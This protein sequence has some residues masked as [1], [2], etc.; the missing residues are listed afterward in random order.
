MASNSIAT[1]QLRR[2]LGSVVHTDRNARWEASFDSS[3]LSYLPD[4]VIKPRNAADIGVALVLANRH[5]VPVTVRGRG[6]TLTG[7]A[8]PLHGGWVVDLTGMHRVRIDAETGMAH[9]QAGATNAAVRAAAEA[10]GWFYPPDPSSDKYCTIGGNI[11]CNAGGMHGGKYGV[12]RDYVLALK[13]F[14]P[15]GEWVEWGTAT[16]KFSAGFNLRDLWIGSEGL[17]GIVT[18]AVLK[19]IPLPS[20][21]WTLLTSF[22]DEVTALRAAREC[23]QIPF[24]RIARRVQWLTSK[25]VL[26]S[27]SRMPPVLLLC[28][29][30]VFEPLSATF[31][32]RI[33]T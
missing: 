9:V 33:L 7:A 6:T 27:S 1:A 2:K 26:P 22:T 21:R 10:E 19:L 31:T 8:V 12:T 4:A 25:S 24:P 20:T 30:T 13:G 29:F 11:A 16:K 3:K 15:T 32:R 28:S 14:L 18:D 17:L 5:R 23:V